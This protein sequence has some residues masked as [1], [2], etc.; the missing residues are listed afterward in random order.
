MVSSFVRC[1]ARS[2][3]VA[4]LIG[5]LLNLSLV[6]NIAASEKPLGMVVASQH[7]RLG[8]ANAVAGADVYSGDTFATDADGS[9]RL[10]L[11]GSQIYLLGSSWAKLLQQENKVR[12]SVKQGTLGFSTTTP[13]QIEIETPLGTIQGANGERMHGQVIVLAADRM[14]VS[15]YQGTL[16]VSAN[17]QEQIVKPGQSYAVSFAPE[18]AAG[19]QAPAGVGKSGVNKRRLAFTLL[20]IGGAAATVGIIWHE[21]TESCSRVNCD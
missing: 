3:L 12:A 1:G 7:A 14:T 6:S 19:G 4:I 16:V 18:A 11:G 8:N 20:A 21:S 2:I 13:G 10:K 9:L 15:A 5:S 17:D